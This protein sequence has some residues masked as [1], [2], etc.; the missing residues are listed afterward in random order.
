MLVIQIIITNKL[1]FD[2]FSVSERSFSFSN[3]GNDHHRDHRRDDDD[4]GQ[5]SSS[6]L[7]GVDH[8][9]RD[10]DKRLGRRRRYHN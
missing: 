10:P 9:R 3:H 4:R 1:T 6:H 5:L 2:Y 7:T 8:S